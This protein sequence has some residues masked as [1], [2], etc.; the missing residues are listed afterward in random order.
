MESEDAEGEPGILG[1]KT[2]TPRFVPFSDRLLDQASVRERPFIRHLLLELP[3]CSV[4]RGWQADSGWL[5]PIGTG[6][7]PGDLFF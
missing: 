6:I 7:L 3:I 2:Y 1:S 5:V 4:D